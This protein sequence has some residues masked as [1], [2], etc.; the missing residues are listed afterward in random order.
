MNAILTKR[1]IKL[2]ILIPILLALSGCK[3]F[4]TGEEHGSEGKLIP[5]EGDV[6]FSFK[7]GYEGWDSEGEPRLSFA[8]CTEKIYGCFNY[9]IVPVISIKEDEID[10]DILGVYVPE[11]CACAHGPA[12]YGSFI[13]IDNGEYSL[14]LSSGDVADEYTLTVTDSFLSIAEDTASLSRPEYKEFWRYPR[15]SFAYQC[16]TTEE[17]S[18]I[19]EDFL[20]YLKAEICSEEFLFPESVWIPYSTLIS[21]ASVMYFLYDDE[22]DFDLAGERLRSYTHDVIGQYSGVRIALVNWKNRKFYSWLLD[23]C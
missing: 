11:I 17:T 12:K 13:E 1:N 10:V 23:D 5:L 9:E 14:V 18:L 16:G 21:D 6:V 3:I 15:N 2:I 19:C 20:E 7:E 8:M 4:G 22:G